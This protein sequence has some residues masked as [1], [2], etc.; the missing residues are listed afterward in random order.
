MDMA[1]KKS[2][3]EEKAKLISKLGQLD[4]QNGSEPMKR[5][6]VKNSSY[7]DSHPYNVRDIAAAV[8]AAGATKVTQGYANGWNNQPKVVIFS[9]TPD[10][11]PDI[12]S[13]VQ[14]TVGTKW[15]IIHEKDW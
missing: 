3:L 12:T 4:V 1:T 8:K 14:T 7:F 10:M 13:E 9:A 15:I 5:Y 6:Y 11:I 2:L